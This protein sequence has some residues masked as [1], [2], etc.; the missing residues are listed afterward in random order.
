[1]IGAIDTFAFS[2][3]PTSFN[4]ESK[5]LSLRQNGAILSRFPKNRLISRTTRSIVMRS[6][7]K[8]LGIPPSPAT[9]FHPSRSF[10]FNFYSL[11]HPLAVFIF[12][13]L[14]LQIFQL[15]SFKYVFFFFSFAA[16]VPFAAAEHPQ[17]QHCL[18]SAGRRCQGRFAVQWVAFRAHPGG[19][20]RRGSK[21]RRL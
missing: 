6:A 18:P 3:F 1:M 17:P 4:I 13:F 19:H 2:S 14:F 12:W 16:V 20:L 15:S 5:M 11:M 7:E 8:V 21:P 9:K 10:F